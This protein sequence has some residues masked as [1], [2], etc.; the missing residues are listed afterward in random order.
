[1]DFS[2]ENSEDSKATP[3]SR[4]KDTRPKIKNFFKMLIFA[5]KSQQ[6]IKN[7]YIHF[8]L[9]FGERKSISNEK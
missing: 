3:I 7:D 9:N 8:F 1:M 4:Y 5:Q 2:T 6:S